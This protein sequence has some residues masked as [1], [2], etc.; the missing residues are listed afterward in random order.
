MSGKDILP[1]KDI[2]FDTLQEVFMKAVIAKAA[3][4]NIPSGEISP[5]ITAQSAWISTWAIARDKKNC[6][7]SQ[8]ERK[9]EAKK[10]YKKLL[11]PFMQRWIFRNKNMDE[12]AITRCGLMPRQLRGAGSQEPP[13]PQLV[14]IGHG[15]GMGELIARCK[16]AEGVEEYGCILVA[17]R[18]LPSSVKFNPLGQLLISQDAGNLIPGELLFIIDQ[19]KKRNK[20]FAGLKPGT[21]YYAYFYTVNYRGVSALSDY[22]CLKCV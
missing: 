20:K 18:Q 21:D 4:W 8:R 19:S 5:L 14:T 7:T 11:R 15:G 22:R 3:V 1:T 10:R 12:A 6:T 16:K 17:G 13:I 2:A 9:D